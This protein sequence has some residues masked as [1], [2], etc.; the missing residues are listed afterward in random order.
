MNFDNLHFTEAYQHS[1]ATKAVLYAKDSEFQG[2]NF[3]QVI[4]E[5]DLK[6]K[7]EVRYK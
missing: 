4:Q 3:K 7:Q 6:E 2:N 5:K 1:K